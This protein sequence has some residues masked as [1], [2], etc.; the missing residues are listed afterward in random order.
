MAF[1]LLSRAQRLTLTGRY[2]TATPK[3]IRHRLLHVAGRIAPSGQRLHLDRDWPWTPTLIHGIH[4][5]R[6]LTNNRHAA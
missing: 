1:N 4:N 2:Q 3:T 5:T 6:N